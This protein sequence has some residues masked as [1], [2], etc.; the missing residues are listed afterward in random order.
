MRVFLDANV[1]LDLIDIDRNRS[2]ST[3]EH[4]K[5]LLL[6]GDELFTSC[7]IFTTVYYVASKKVDHETLIEELEKLFTFVS[8]LPIDFD[9]VT[10]AL[11]LG[12]Q[13]G[14]KDLE[15]ILQYLC[16]KKNRCTLILTHDRDFFSPDIRTEPCE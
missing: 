14:Q 1:I 11:R 2:F 4:L 5:K 12:K 15:D 13:T 9:M 3:K 6:Q 10:E 7:D 8:V 16:A